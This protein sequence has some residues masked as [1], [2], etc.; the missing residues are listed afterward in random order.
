MANLVFD[1]S[2]SENDYI[3]TIQTD[4]T[5]RAPAYNLGISGEQH[6]GFL[7][8]LLAKYPPRYPLLDIA[9]G[10]ALLGQLLGRHGDGVTGLDLTEAMLQHARNALPKGT[11]VQG[12]AENLPFPDASF[13]S[14]YVCSA[15]VYFTD[16]DAV[17]REA[18][19]VLE[20][21]AFFAYQAVS[22]DSYVAGVE[23]QNALIHVFGQQ[24]ARQ[25]FELPHGITNDTEANRKLMQRAGFD[26]IRAEM[27]VTHEK[28]DVQRLETMWDNMVG[29]NALLGRVR[30]LS[31]D[32][33]QRLRIRWVQ[34][35]EDRRDVEGFVPDKIESWY[36]CGWKPAK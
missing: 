17:L 21:G 18:Y 24:R 29:N 15:I 19:R 12:R 26:N 13:Q 23:L 7:N 22:L 6:R 14:V 31:S 35:L 28:I 3:R 10:T 33:L 16:V 32:E 8:T 25:L 4:F 11:F 5:R 1:D 30:A 20:N 36:V 2:Y 34:G 27:E 9:C